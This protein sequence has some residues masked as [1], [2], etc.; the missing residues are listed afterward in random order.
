[1]FPKAAVKQK[2]WGK[3]IWWADTP[4]YAGKILEVVRGARLSL[5]FHRKKEETQYLFAG[6][7]IITYGTD[8]KKL[9]KKTLLPG[10]AFHIKPKTI[11]RIE[12]VA[13]NSIIFEVSTPHLTDVVR[14]SDDYGRPGEGNHEKLDKTIA[15]ATRGR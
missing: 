15:K 1:M 14:L 12:G 9:K 10:Q 8:P 3:E 5:Q 4:K 13:K 7:V 6:K 11:H 2:P